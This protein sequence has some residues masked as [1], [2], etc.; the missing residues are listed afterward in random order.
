MH[1][2]CYNHFTAMCYSCYLVCSSLPQVSTPKCF[3]D[4]PG[5][6]NKGNTCYAN[7]ALQLLYHCPDFREGLRS[8]PASST[9]SNENA[10]SE[11]LWTEQPKPF[12]QL[13]KTLLELFYML[14]QGKV[15]QLFRSLI[16]AHW[17]KNRSSRNGFTLTL[18]LFA[19][20]DAFFRI[21]AQLV[22]LTFSSHTDFTVIQL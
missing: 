16:V 20:C 6:R 9:A 3:A 22:R 11:R 1:T 4:L 10:D 21:F 17:R 14:S 2:S 15:S 19:K 8:L 12:G 13:H 5:L 18:H 7:A